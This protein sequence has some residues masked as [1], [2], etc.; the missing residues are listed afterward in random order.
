V[1]LFESCSEEIVPQICERSSYI[2]YAI[3]LIMLYQTE[4]TKI[5]LKP[6]GGIELELIRATKDSATVTK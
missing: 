5:Q 1:K 3:K 4:K 6:A 2:D